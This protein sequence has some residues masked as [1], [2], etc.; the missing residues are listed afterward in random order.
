[1]AE[2]GKYGSANVSAATDTFATWLERTNQIVED[3]A[4]IVVT[5]AANSTGALT[6]GNAVVNGIF[7]ANTLAIPTGLRGGTVA[8]PATLTISTNTSVTGTVN[9]TANVNVTNKLSV[10]NSATMV[11]V[12]VQN[13]RPTTN[14]TFALGTSA[15]QFANVNATEVYSTNVIANNA[16]FSLDVTMDATVAFNNTASFNASVNTDIVPV[17]LRALGNTTTAW[18]QAYITNIDS[19]TL[20]TASLNTT[21]KANVATLEAR[22]NTFINNGQLVI[23]NTTQNTFTVTENGTVTANGNLTVQGVAS[24]T[25]N[26]TISGDL[27]INGNTSLGSGIAL[28]VA[29]SQIVDLTVSNTA[30]VT[31]NTILGDT[32]SDIVRFVAAVNSA[33]IP[34]GSRNLGNTSNRW[35]ILYAANTEVSGTANVATANINN[36]TTATLTVTGNS[37]LNVVNTNIVPT[38]TRTIG[39]TTVDWSVIYVANTQ[40][41][42]TAN[43]NNLT[44]AGTTTLGD[45]TADTINATARFSSNVIPNANGTR[46]LGQ[47]GLRW[48]VFANTATIATVNTNSVS[49]PSNLL[50]DT[51]ANTITLRT[52]NNTNLKAST[53][54]TNEFTIWHSGNDGAGSGLDADLLDGQTGAY[55]TNATNISTGTLNANRLATSGVTAASYGNSTSIP[56]LTVDNKGRVTAASVV[57]VAGVSSFAFT[58]AN[59]T[60]TI[61]TADGGSF[62]SNIST[63]GA[64]IT[65]PGVTVATGG[66]PQVILDDTDSSTVTANSGIFWKDSLDNIEHSVS[67]VNTSDLQIKALGDIIFE[68]SGND[69]YPSSNNSYD[70]GTSAK[71]WVDGWF[72]N[73]VYATTFSGSLSGN[74]STATKLATARTISITGDASGSTTF[75]GAANKSISISL[76]GGSVD[77]NELAS[78]AVTSAKIESGAV[79]TTQLAANSVT[80]AKLSNRQTLSILNSSGTALKTIHWPGD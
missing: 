52:S 53:N 17:G 22:G 31:G 74:A 60:L 69:V 58:Q 34:T 61:S 50:V 2:S 9:V 8:A 28:S 70:F 42:G 21:G 45:A 39:N 46:Q 24:I 40:V 64:S 68:P 5:A 54:T 77:T 37:S 47:A 72:S 4:S 10:G 32:T 43:V 12:F 25:G 44:V 51:G 27:T 56:V 19:T 11:D 78:G 48:Q 76:A 29:N 26:T 57:T 80:Q 15:N 63:F 7:Q 14:A 59:N 67:V 23:A 65:A 55:Y 79:G 75:D 71:R 1:M 3:M 73:T 49:A 33:I 41:S 6:T 35:A 13:I 36:T 66:A 16:T 30:T 18:N 62:K 20:D 38:G